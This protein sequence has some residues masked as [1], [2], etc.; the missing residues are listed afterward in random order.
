MASTWAFFGTTMS[1]LTI[2]NMPAVPST[3][4]RMW[5]WKAHTPGRSAVTRTS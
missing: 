3:W 1:V 4:G 2:P 5:Q